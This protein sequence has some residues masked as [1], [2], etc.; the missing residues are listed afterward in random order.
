MDQWNRIESPEINTIQSIFD[1]GGRNIQWRKRPSLQPVVLGKLDSH[2]SVNEVRTHPHTG[3]TNSKCLKELNTRHDMIKLLEENTGRT[4]SDINCT[5][6]FLGQ[7][8]KATEIKTKINKWD[9]IKT[10]I[11][12]H[13]TAVRMAIIKK[14]TNNKCWR[15]CGETGTLLHC[16]WEYKLVQ[17]L[18]K[19]VSRFLRKLKI[20]L[21]YDPA[22]PLQGMYLD[23]I[24]I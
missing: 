2:M 12:Y 22:I 16:W 24:I 17:P 7:S 8:P 21:P 1:K 23:K 10:T 14:S 19:T 9:Q 4:L 15:G 13:L 20:E 6:V 5:N 18:W 3:K 11:K